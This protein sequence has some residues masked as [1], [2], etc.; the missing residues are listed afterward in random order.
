MFRVRLLDENF[1]PEFVSHYANAMGQKYFFDEGK[2]TT[3]LAS[4][5]KRKVS[6]LPVP[7]PPASEAVEI[8][9]QIET[10]FTKID[11]LALETEK[12]LKL[13]DNLDQ[14]LLIKAFVGELV[15]QDPNDEPASVL[16]RRIQKARANIPKKPRKKLKKAKTM[17][18]APQ[19]R[20]L[21]DSAD[22]PKAGLPFEDIAKRIALSHDDL[23]D[24]VFALLEGDTPKLQQKF[25]IDAQI[26]K[27]MRVAS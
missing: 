19:D 13:T 9:N 14:R 1:P 12:A 25:D 15:S 20:I 18:I 26:M 21:I 22:W 2:Q 24:A 11:R 6:S 7:I 3:N 5:N 23:K 4:I 27:L 16:L 8:V 10:A 17:K